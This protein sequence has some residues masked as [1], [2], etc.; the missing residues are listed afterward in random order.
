[1]SQQARPKA[2]VVAQVSCI[3]VGGGR[4]MADLR[5]DLDG[6]HDKVWMWGHREREKPRLFPRF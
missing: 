5:K 2:V 4:E 1:M 6:N 3:E